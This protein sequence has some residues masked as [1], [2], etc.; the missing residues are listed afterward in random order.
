[1]KPEKCV[2]L[3][4]SFKGS[5]TSRE[6]GE[7]VTEEMARFFPSC[8]VEA[9]PAADGGEGTA[10][11]LAGVCGGNTVKVNS[12]TGPVG[13]KIRAGYVVLPDGT[14]V[15]E[16]A[17]AAGLP[18][19]EGRED[20]GRATTFGVGQLMVHALEHGAKRIVL[21][22]GGSAT[23]D[24]GTGCA[25]ALGAEFFNS[26]GEAFIPTGNTLE[27]IVHM[28]LR[29]LKSRLEGVEITAICD[30]TNPMHGPEGAAF[31]YAPQKGADPAEVE[32]L[33]RNLKA[34]DRLFQRELGLSVA[35]VPGAGAAGAFGAGVLALLGGRLKRG[36]DT[37]LDLIGFEELISDADL[38]I[39]G[40]GRLDSQSFCGKV[41]GTVGQRAQRLGIPVYALVG[42]VDE[43]GLRAAQSGG[44]TAVYPITPAG[45]PIAQ[46]RLHSRDYYRSALDKMLEKI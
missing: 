20:P 35:E 12:I 26:R 24:C 13:E 28:D 11:C 38:V 39:T 19:A 22:L 18:L 9:I 34:M 23:N 41:V 1:M 43:E 3:S 4:D 32:L 21:G 42:Q 29:A 16:M 45:E 30:V 27:E 40:E 15:V 6:I 36:I 31:V 2:V 44:I 14:A 17:A 10:E 46:A 33:D 8:R 5:L 7:L 25:A 37:I